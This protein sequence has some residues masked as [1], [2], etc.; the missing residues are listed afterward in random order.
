MHY[1]FI[2]F[3]LLALGVAVVLFAALVMSAAQ[4][5]KAEREYQKLLAAQHKERSKA[6]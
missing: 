1:A 6:G 5:R 3:G 2:A 4:E